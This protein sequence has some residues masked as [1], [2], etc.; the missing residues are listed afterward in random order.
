MFVVYVCGGQ[1]CGDIVSAS[2]DGAATARLDSEN[3]S[4]SGLVGRIVDGSRRRRGYGTTLS[5]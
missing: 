1:G 3:S 5:R 2:V 4:E